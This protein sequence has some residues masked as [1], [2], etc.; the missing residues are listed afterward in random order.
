L[1]GPSRDE[2]E[3][4][5]EVESGHELEEEVRKKLRTRGEAQVP[6]EDKEPRTEE[7]KALIYPNGVE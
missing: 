6:D 3:T 7:A 2:A 1:E 5:V 4:E